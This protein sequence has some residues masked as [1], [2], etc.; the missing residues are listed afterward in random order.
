MVK[1]NIKLKVACI[2]KGINLKAIAKKAGIQ[3]SRFSKILNGHMKPRIEEKR[4]LSKILGR[5]QKELF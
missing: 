2:H 3:A 4:I 5:P 1:G